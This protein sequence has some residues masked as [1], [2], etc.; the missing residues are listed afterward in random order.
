MSWCYV[1]LGDGVRY[2]D[3]GYVTL[4]GEFLMDH[5][6]ATEAELRAAFPERGPIKDAQEKV[7]LAG[8]ARDERDRQLRDIYDAGTQMIRRELETD[9]IDPVYEAKLITKRSELH[10]YAKLLLA[11]PEQSAFPETIV[12]PEIPTEELS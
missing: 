7:R 10:A 3:D 6:P 5:Y 1:N 9:P 12:W 4:E 8:V 2:V 11:I